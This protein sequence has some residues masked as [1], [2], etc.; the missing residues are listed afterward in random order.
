[1]W[2]GSFDR[3]LRDIFAIQDE[4]SRGI[5]NNLRLKLATPTV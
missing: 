4:I 1:L 5:V 3:E 2:S